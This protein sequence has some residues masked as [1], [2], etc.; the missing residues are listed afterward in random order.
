M[1]S[2][3]GKSRALASKFHGQLSLFFS[4]NTKRSQ[5]QHGASHAGKTCSTSRRRSP[6]TQPYAVGRMRVRS[7]VLVWV[8]WE[9]S[10][11]PK[12]QDDSIIR[13]RKNP[14]FSGELPRSRKIGRTRA[15]CPY[16]KDLQG[17]APAAKFQADSRGLKAGGTIEH[18]SLGR[19]TNGR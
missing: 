4:A 10:A 16:A 19:V 9:N 18:Q 8:L 5:C 7:A 1:W 14:T 12:Q 6:K 11:F 2:P 3:N 15:F 17:H 13:L